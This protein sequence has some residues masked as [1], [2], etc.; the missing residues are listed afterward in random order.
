MPPCLSVAP[1]SDSD[2][3]VS[4]CSHEGITNMRYNYKYCNDKSIGQQRTSSELMCY[5]ISNAIVDCRP[6]MYLYDK[7]NTIFISLVST[8]LLVIVVG[9]MLNSIIIVRFLQL[10]SIQKRI[11]N[12]LLLNQAVADM[13]NCLMYLTPLIVTHFHDV[14]YTHYPVILDSLFG[15]A[16]FLSVA[17]SLFIFLVI[18]FE[19]YLSIAKPLWHRV[20]LRKLHIRRSIVASWLVAMIFAAIA[21]YL[22]LKSYNGEKE[23]FFYY[24][25]ALHG[26]AAILM[27]VVTILFSLTFYKA[28]LSIRGKNIPGAVLSGRK[29]EFHITATFTVMYISFLTCFIPLAFA[30][31][32]EKSP[33]NRLKILCFSLTSITNPILTFRLRKE[34]RIGKRS[35]VIQETLTGNAHQ[36]DIAADNQ[37]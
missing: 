11:A 27:L 24:T 35:N 9:I 6:Y 19:R 28:L 8:Q 30:D 13:V 4:L 29:K 31:D 22:Y 37:L 25:K 36:I 10:L 2:I 32:S 18:A 1:E 23:I 20:N 16:A 17:S 12:I 14:T 7:C 15:S 34:F 26:I 33:K 5:C 21:F 3:F